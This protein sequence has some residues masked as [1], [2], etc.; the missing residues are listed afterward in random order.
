[1]AF[2]IHP[3]LTLLAS[4]TRQELAKQVAYLRAENRILRNKLPK[5]I[6]LSIHERSQ[7]VKH[8]KSLGPRIRESI[9]VVS[10]STF[11]RWVRSMEATPETGSR[12]KVARA[13][14]PRVEEGVHDAI[15]RIRKETGWGYTRIVQAMRRLGHTIS[16]Q[17]VK[18]VLVQAG[19]GPEPQDHPEYLEYQANHLIAA[20]GRS[21]ERTRGRANLESRIPGTTPE[22][23]PITIADRRNP[24]G[25]AGKA[26]ILKTTAGPLVLNAV[27]AEPHRMTT[28]SRN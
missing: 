16:R 26:P 10:Y 11:R 5:Q 3:L 21:I 1:M 23:P 18:N 9:S 12:K 6:E 19:L 2:L 25:S 14:R 22:G 27:A 13:G 20:R 8:G 7:L 17:T 28:G 15:I 24:P 4:L